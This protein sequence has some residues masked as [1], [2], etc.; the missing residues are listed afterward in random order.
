MAARKNLR[1]DQKT[2]DKI[3]A[4]QLI[5]RLT[6]HALGDEEIMTNSQVNAARIL[7]NKTIPDLSNIDLSGQVDSSVTVVRKEYKPSN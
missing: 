6:N 3:Q 4:S 2:R 5:N 7:L 1:H